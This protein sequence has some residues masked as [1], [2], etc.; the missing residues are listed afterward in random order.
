MVTLLVA[1]K[2]FSENQAKVPAK[3]QAAQKL[4]FTSRLEFNQAIFTSCRAGC[5]FPGDPLES[6]K[7]WRSE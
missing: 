2:F 7:K 4:F 1:N 3:F 5:L 6:S